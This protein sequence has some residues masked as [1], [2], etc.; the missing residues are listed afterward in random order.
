MV[1]VSRKEAVIQGTGEEEIVVVTMTPHRLLV[2]GVVTGTLTTLLTTGTRAKK[3][4]TRSPKKSA[5]T[6]G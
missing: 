4:M 3:T 2:M 5:V 1:T 6:E